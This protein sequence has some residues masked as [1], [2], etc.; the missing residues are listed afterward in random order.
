M[1]SIGCV[2]IAALF[3][4][5]GA[6][7]QFVPRQDLSTPYLT[8]SPPPDPFSN[9]FDPHPRTYATNE[10]ATP[11][12]KLFKG[13]F[14]TDPRLLFGVALTPNLAL[15]AGYVN[16]L[17]QG[18]HRIDQRNAGDTDGALGTRGS[19][20]HAAVRFTLPVSDRL[21]MFGKLGVAWSKRVETRDDLVSDKAAQANGL[22]ATAQG[23]YT[24]LGAKYRINE[25]MT[26]SG[27]YADHGNGK[28]WGPFTNANGVR[29]KLKVGF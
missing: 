3:A 5:G 24:G 11:N 17:D 23:M 14:K 13:L 9:S 22:P 26:I 20:V 18:F 21:S 29:A 10:S 28:E 4:A 25:R 12:D 16:L 15:E 27:E 8:K 2:L 19:S 7:A 1:K 6:H